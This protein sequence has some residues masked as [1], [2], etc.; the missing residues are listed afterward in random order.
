MHNHNNLLC[1]S[2]CSILE[3]II[4]LFFLIYRFFKNIPILILF[5]F[6]SLFP[7]Q[8]CCHLHMF[9]F[10]AEICMLCKQ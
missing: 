4:N 1:N 7:P 8:C 3:K 5:I 9:D 2:I 6:I 10:V